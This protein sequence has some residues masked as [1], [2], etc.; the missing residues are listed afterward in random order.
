LLV[1]GIKVADGYTKALQ[2]VL[3]ERATFLVVDEVTSVAR[4]FQELV[5][6]ADP[7]NKRGLGIG[8]FASI[9]AEEGNL[10]PTTEFPGVTHLL[11]HVETLEWSRPIVS[12]LLSKVWVAKDLD[13]A[14]GF[15]ESEVARTGQA[16]A[17]TVVVTLSGDLISPWSFYSLRHDGG[18]IQVKSKVDEAIH[19]ITENQ[20]RYDQAAQERDSVVLAISE[21]ERRHAELT[22]SI[23]EAQ[24]RLREMSN[25]Q[26]EV[27]GRVQSESKMYQ[28]L[29]ND[30]E[31]IEPQRVEV[32]GQVE[33]LEGTLFQIREEIEQLRQRDNTE[34]EGE[35]N[36]IAVHLKDLEENRRG[37]RDEFTQLLRSIEMKRR[38]HDAVRDS[39]V[40]ERMSAE[41]IRGE[42]QSTEA[43]VR[44][45]HGADVLS[46]ILESAEKAELLVQELRN[47]LE[48]RVSSI[49][50]RLE[51]EGEVDPSVI[52]QHEVE[53]RRLEELT[54]QRQ[55]LVKASETLQ[56]TLGELSE[57]CTRRFVATFEA[58]RSN[59]AVF[60]PKLFGGGSAELR[61]ID[62]ANPLESGVEVVVRPPGK[63]PKS[64][65]L[66]SGGEK[67]LCAIAM[68]FS[69][70]MVRPSP[71]CVLDEVDAPLDEANVQRYIAFIK[72]M[73]S[74]TQFLMIT[75]NKASM[76]AADSLVGVT[77]P[78]PGA[79][80]IL[81]VSL[82][83]AVKQVA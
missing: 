8:L 70:F 63:K 29:Q 18:I 25:Q 32:Q 55:D 33:T 71:I 80:K 52:E 72:E 7:S 23:H 54:T 34:L 14:M 62:P 19:T 43:S 21:K 24:K 4:S 28:Q 2:S 6:K 31:R 53:S 10:L 3:A 20:A 61:L 1:D 77:M 46:T 39:L 13:T 17:D 59:F 12:R 65:D 81:T 69:M 56:V 41:R 9:P 79:S 26:A 82:Q 83:E 49:R 57:A 60:G 58:I 68:V 76:A 47:Q 73:S 45:R 78:T 15:I 67:A 48:H 66:L 27:R 5:L 37:L 35:L 64:I 50:Q 30:I 74:R 36:Q 44:E 51:R 40:R 22:R 16:D 42:L 75:H 11:S 38:A